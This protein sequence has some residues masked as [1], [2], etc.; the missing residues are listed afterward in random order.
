MR[1]AACGI[2]VT[3]LAISVFGM[4]LTG[5]AQHEARVYRIGLLSPESPPPGLLQEVEQELGRL[6]Y[7][8]GET[9]TIEVRHAGGKSHGLP[10]LADQLVRRK[11]DAILAV[12]SSAVAAAKKATTTIP[13]VMVRVADPVRTGLVSDLA[14]PGGNITGLSFT[15][16]ELSVK[17]LQ[18]LKEV[19]PS[20]SRAAVL[21]YAGNPGTAVVI[22]EMDAVSPQL[23]LQ[24]IRLPV[25]GPEDLRRAAETATRDR[26]EA[27][28]LLDDAFITR[29]REQILNLAAQRRLPVVSLYKP[30]VAAGGLFAYGAST[31]AIYRRTGGPRITSTNFSKARSRPISP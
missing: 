14:R 18:L 30:F 9:L 3:V 19:M 4:P 28:V 24:L 2:V 6:G 31:A 27:L 21:W 15:V 23:G 20:I 11:V 7:V 25:Q 1:V 10:P 8:Q 29:H 22:K 13:I 26:A 5:E 16:E 17:R 12:N